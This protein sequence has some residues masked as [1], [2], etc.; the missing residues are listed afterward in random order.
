[1]VHEFHDI[2]TNVPG[3]SV[4]ARQDLDLSEAA[5]LCKDKQPEK[6]NKTKLKKN[7]KILQIYLEKQNREAVTTIFKFSQTSRN[8]KSGSSVKQIPS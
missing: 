8:L 2:S 4:H 7:Q 6:N 3:L 1:M 5:L